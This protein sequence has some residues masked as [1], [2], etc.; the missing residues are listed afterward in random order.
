MFEVK[1]INMKLLFVGHIQPGS[2]T[3]QRLLAF[4]RIG[5]NVL[6]CNVDGSLPFF[7][8]YLDR[9]FC[10]YYIYLDWWS[11]NKRILKFV[12]DFNPNIIWIEKGLRIRRETLI[13]LKNQSKNIQIVGYSCDDLILKRNLSFNLINSFPFYDHFITTKSYNVEELKKFGVMNARFYDNAYDNTVYKL[14]N[15]DGKYKYDLSFVGGFEEERFKSIIFLADANFIIHVFGPGWQEYLGFHKNIIVKGGW[16]M[17]DEVNQIF[18][19]TKVNLHFLRKVARDLQTTRSMEIPGSCS[20]MLA[21]DTSEHRN[22]FAHEKE[23]VFFSSDEDLLCKVKYYLINDFER[24]KIKLAGH[25]RSINSFYSYDKILLKIVE[26][27]K[28]K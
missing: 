25:K 26:D 7:L 11:V 20:F 6:D 17:E 22:L 4:K 21:E 8:K 9:I 2:T 5:F 13:K 19:Q 3:K 1:L 18:N 27:I 28:S 10:H 12:K 15:N 23:A 24:E 16:I 14:I